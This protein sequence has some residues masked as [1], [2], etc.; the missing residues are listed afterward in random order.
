[1]QEVFKGSGK[2]FSTAKPTANIIIVATHLLTKQ[3]YAL[4][5]FTVTSN[6]SHYTEFTKQRSCSKALTIAMPP[7]YKQD[8]AVP[9]PYHKKNKTMNTNIII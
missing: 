4:R 5:K 2:S 6:L 3:R 9:A 7:P 8:I 1:M